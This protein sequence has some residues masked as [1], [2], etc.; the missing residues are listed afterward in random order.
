[1]SEVMQTYWTN[2]AKNGNPNGPGVPTWPSFDPASRAYL[3][4]MD[5][6]AVAKKRLRQPFC[7]LFLE[8]ARR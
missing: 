2:F 7:D 8:N 5:E 1:M 6:G 4:F 3:A